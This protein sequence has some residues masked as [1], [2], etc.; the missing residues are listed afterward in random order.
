MKKFVRPNQEISEKARIKA[1]LDTLEVSIIYITMHSF[2]SLKRHLT[3][4]LELLYFLYEHSY[5]K[6]EF[7]WGEYQPFVLNNVLYQTIHYAE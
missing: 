6:F 4:N 7:K 1:S 3:L 2:L 5:L